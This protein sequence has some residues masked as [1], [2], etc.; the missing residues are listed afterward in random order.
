MKVKPLNIFEPDQSTSSSKIN[1]KNKQQVAV[2]KVDK[3]L[4]KQLLVHSEKSALESSK[5]SASSSTRLLSSTPS[6]SFCKAENPT[7]GIRATASSVLFSKLRKTSTSAVTRTKPILS[8]P[9]SRLN[10][11]DARFAMTALKLKYQRLAVNKSNRSA[12][13]TKKG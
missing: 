8:P 3:S 7:L 1:G 10:E 9:R 13:L 12:F 11:Q 6:N 4:N 2:S 5:K